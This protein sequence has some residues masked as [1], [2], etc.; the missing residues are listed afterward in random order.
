MGFTVSQAEATYAA[1][2][3]SVDV[4][5]TDMGN[6]PGLAMMGLGWAM[7]EVDRETATG[8]ERTTTFRGH[9]AYEKADDAGYAELQVLVAGR[10]LVE[11]DGSG[12]TMDQ[13]KGLVEAIDFDALENMRDEGRAS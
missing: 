8:Y 3:A 5:I 10:F 2:D 11:A 9:R 12:T 7:G 4:K 13:L 1:G 6:F